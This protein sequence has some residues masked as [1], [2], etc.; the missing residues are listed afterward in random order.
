LN[1]NWAKSSQSQICLPDDSCD[2]FLIVLGIAHFQLPELP[3]NLSRE[4]L[5]DLANPTDKYKLENAVGIGL[6]MENWTQ[7]HQQDYIQRLPNTRLQD[8]A[9]INSTLGLRKEVE[10]IFC[11]LA[12]EVMVDGY[13]KYY[14][15]D[16]KKTR[17]TLRSD[18][19]IPLSG[20]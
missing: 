19:P 6:Q 2:A 5:L 16:G 7:P 20:M 12:T 1:G 14:Y 15:Y 10:H 18:L 11:R 13:G 17:I 4:E 9:L 8:Y 3:D